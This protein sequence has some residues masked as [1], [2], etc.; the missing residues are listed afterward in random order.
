MPLQL[1]AI[2]LILLLIILYNY[3]KIET[4]IEV[5]HRL[6]QRVKQRIKVRINERMT[7]LIKHYQNK[8]KTLKNIQIIYIITTQENS[9]NLE[10]N[11]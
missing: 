2:K 4:K 6:H 9:I 5:E 1:K 7:E 8:K 3:M 10:K 11:I